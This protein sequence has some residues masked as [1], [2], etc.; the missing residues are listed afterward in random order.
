[1]RPPAP[2]AAAG[3]DTRTRTGSSQHDKVGHLVRGAADLEFFCAAARSF[4]AVPIAVFGAPSKH[5]IS[6]FFH[7]LRL[8]RCRLWSRYVVSAEA[9]PT[10]QPG[11]QPA[12][13]FCAGRNLDPLVVDGRYHEG[14]TRSEGGTDKPARLP[15]GWTGPVSTHGTPG[16][17]KPPG[18]LLRGHFPP[19]AAIAASAPTAG[20]L[21]MKFSQT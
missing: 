5:G 10:D 9:S 15:K 11:R 3:P 14:S 12:R 20:A 13:S 7:P 8:H 19:I 6:G 17:C 4:V 1:M 2:F 18:F 21:Q 16:G